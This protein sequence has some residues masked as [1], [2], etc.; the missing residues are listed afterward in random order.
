MAALRVVWIASALAW[1]VSAEQMTMPLGAG[2]VQETTGGAPAPPTVIHLVADDLGYHDTNWKNHQV[3]T[4]ALD[5]LV[6]A[7]IEIP[8]F[9]VY[10]MCA[11]SRGSVLTGRYPWH[12]GY[13]AN[14]GGG[15]PPLGFKLLPE[16]L[17]PTYDSHML[18]KVSH[19]RHRTLQPPQT[20]L[21]T[22]ALTSP[23]ACWSSSGT[24]DGSSANIPRV[25]VDSKPFMAPRAI[26]MTTGTT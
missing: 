17:S 8:D 1:N 2:R 9:Y 21:A 26:Q 24:S 7:G 23:C 3:S 18:G 15:G 10:K 5:T 14:N 11:P 6:K 12:V 13:Y 20:L 19:Y 22:L 4:D 25:G 16:L